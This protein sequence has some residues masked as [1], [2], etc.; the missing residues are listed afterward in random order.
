MAE[1]KNQYGEC[2]ICKN[3]SFERK[4]G[5]IETVKLKVQV[6]SDLSS[7]K[8]K[9]LTKILDNAVKDLKSTV[10]KW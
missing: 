5:Y 6:D 8:V 2:E 9:D 7:E 10:E 3:F 4:S 1:L